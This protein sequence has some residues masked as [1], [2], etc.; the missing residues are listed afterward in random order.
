MSEQVH[1]PATEVLNDLANPLAGA[2][3]KRARSRTVLWQIQQFIAMTAL[4][5]GCYFAIS[6]F[7]LQSV[8]VTGTSMVPTL[9]NAERYLL[10][11]WIFHVRDPQRGEV[12][13]L[14]DPSDNGYSVKRVIA[15]S[16]DTV[17][18]INGEVYLNGRK[19]VEPYLAPSTPTFGSSSKEQVFHCQPGCYFLLGDNRKD[20][21]DS[22]AYGPVPRRN[23][24][25]L[26]VR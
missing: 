17:S 1:P 3:P 2:K 15:V 21:I 16:G 20:S 11:R 12:V 10:N 23:I 25:G 4:A 18:F 26:V 19:L 9:A 24:L 8:T 7:V 22:R 13:V 6:R 5:I 14:R